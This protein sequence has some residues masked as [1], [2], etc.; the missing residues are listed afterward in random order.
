MT[1]AQAKNLDFLR[2][3][4]DPS[5]NG[6]QPPP[7][8]TPALFPKKLDFEGNFVIDDSAL[9]AFEQIPTQTGLIVWLPQR[10]CGS[11][12]RMGIVP[13]GKVSNSG[14]NGLSQVTAELT[15]IQWNGQV[16]LPYL[17]NTT[18]GDQLK[19]SPDLASN[20][21]RARIYA[22]KVTVLSDS[23]PIGNTV[24]NGVLSAS[25]VSDSR[26]VDFVQQGNTISS[27]PIDAIVQKAITEK[28][29]LKQ[30]KIADGI[31]TIL[32]PD[33]SP[34][35]E[36]PEQDIVDCF[37]SEFLTSQPALFPA[38]TNP[39]SAGASIGIN[40]PLMTTWFSPLPT[41][42]TSTNATHNNVTLP[43][44][45]LT[46]VLDIEGRA[47]V[48]MTAGGGAATSD[49]YDFRVWATHVFAGIASGHKCQFTIFDELVREAVFHDI[50]EVS[51]V[52]K[53]I[54]FRTAPR[55]LMTSYVTVG[56]YIG[57][58]FSYN[59]VM[60]SNVGG[61]AANNNT[62]LLFNAA[63]DYRI[64]AHDISKH[65]NKGPIHIIR[66]DNASNGQNMRVDGEVFAECV[67]EGD[68][69]AF[70]QSMAQTT[71]ATYNVNTLP[72]INALYDMMGTPFRRTWNTVDYKAFIADIDKYLT[73]TMLN[74][75]NTANQNVK[76]AV[77]SAGL[78]GGL[79]SGVGHLV[80]A[81]I[82]DVFG[83][84]GKFGAGGQFG[85]AGEFGAGGQFGAGSRRPG[86]M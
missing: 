52:F 71:D 78:F 33:I 80:G 13:S 40:V 29:A 16:A 9:G 64:G 30:Q 70:T 27:F 81:G 46:G 77:E 1:V 26:D 67:P 2:T 7:M 34:F 12:W 55:K 85:C 48:K 42:V 76:G 53:D 44:I 39:H 36:A 22:G 43:N 65:G 11:M 56:R 79:L 68:I 54:T 50:T 17:Q 10:G 83:T 19:F 3:T 20:F 59:L 6:T 38:S 45:N 75:Y 74:T 49:A 60:T 18:T 47:Q 72:L 25:V 86:R 57:T 31:T 37:H 41:T 32:G 35:F 66:W 5:M 21:S 84:S 8:Y 82:D 51:G 24:L 4:L 61:A 62:L 28:E 63:P 58:F 15:Q 23:V 14:V 73:P 69:T